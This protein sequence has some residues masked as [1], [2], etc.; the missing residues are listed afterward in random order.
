MVAVFASLTPCVVFIHSVTRASVKQV[1]CFSMTIST[2]LLLIVQRYTKCNKLR[3]CEKHVLEE[4]WR[5]HRKSRIGK[6]GIVGYKIW[7]SGMCG[8]VP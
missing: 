1:L 6:S 8:N 2:Q 3:N 5:K 4:L 7:R